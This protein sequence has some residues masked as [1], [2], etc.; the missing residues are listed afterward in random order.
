MWK[1]GNRIA[2]TVST[3]KEMGWGRWDHRRDIDEVEMPVIWIAYLHLG[4]VI[5]GTRE[6]HPDQ[7]RK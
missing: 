5:L 2:R 6:I 1:V 4:K 7:V 3:C